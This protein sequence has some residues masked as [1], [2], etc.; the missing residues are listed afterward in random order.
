MLGS[1]CIIGGGIG[2]LTAAASLAKRGWSVALYERESALRAHGSGIYLWNNGLA[3]LADLGVLDEAIEGA[4]Y[5]PALET[6]NAADEIMASVQTGLGKPVT[7]LTA[8]RS[9]LID[10]LARACREFGVDVHTDMEGVSAHL[11]GSVSFADGTEAT[12]DL[13]VVADGVN[14]RIRDG[15]ALTKSR[16]GLGQ[17]GTRALIPRTPGVLPDADEPKYIEWMAGR[18]FVLWTPI[19]DASLYIS[20]VSPRGHPSVAPRLDPVVWTDD[21]PQLA[22]LFAALNGYEL[23]WAE[24]EHITLERWSAGRVAVLGDAAHAQ[25]PYLGQGGGCAMMNAVGLAHAVT[26][27][28]GGIPDRLRFWEETERPLI[29]YTQNFSTGVAQLNDL[30]ESVRTTFVGALG[31]SADFGRNRLRAAMTTPTGIAPFRSAAV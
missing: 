12:A 8:T 13:V 31:A 16:V 28:G 22:G 2:G 23:H 17:M 6:R 10:G 1:A 4:H 18:R 15:L 24:F 14:S 20:L 7:V 5:G 27:G 19:S 11:D 25:P 26:V 30:P 29:E 3:V 21:F 9:R